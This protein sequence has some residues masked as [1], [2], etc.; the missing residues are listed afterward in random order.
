[1]L[2]I[3]YGL[4]ARKLL[5]CLLQHRVLLEQHANTNEI[6]DIVTD[7]QVYSGIISVEFCTSMCTVGTTRK[8]ENPDIAV[9]VGRRPKVFLSFWITPF[10]LVI[11]FIG[12]LAR[13]L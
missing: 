1:M 5:F 4:L 12:L 6:F 9:V 8:R 11:L 3:V 7:V 2:I 13:K 10:V